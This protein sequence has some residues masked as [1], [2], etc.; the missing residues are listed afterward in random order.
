MGPAL[1]PVRTNQIRKRVSSMARAVMVKFN[2]RPEQKE[3]LLAHIHALATQVKD[4]DGTLAW[5]GHTSIEDENEL[6]MYELFSDLDGFEA[7]HAS[8][9]HVRA[10]EALPE[11]LAT[12]PEVHKLDVAVVGKGVLDR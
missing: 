12:D 5:V 8:P 11:C 1:R 3:N 2:V 4:E 10:M 9:V 7:H 6:W